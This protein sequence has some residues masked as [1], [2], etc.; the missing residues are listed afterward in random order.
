L[1]WNYLALTKGAISASAIGSG[2]N[3][4][5][6]PGGA[7]IASGPGD[8]LRPGHEIVAAEFALFY[9]ALAETLI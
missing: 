1:T 5:A 6:K 4:A 3:G 2:S 8:D 9:S 7:S